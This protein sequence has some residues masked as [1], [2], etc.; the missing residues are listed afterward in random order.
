MREILL[1]HNLSPVRVLD[2]GHGGCHDRARGWT[3]GRID[4]R[5]STT[6]GLSKRTV[7]LVRAPSRS[8]GNCHCDPVTEI[9]RYSYAALHRMSFGINRVMRLPDK[10]PILFYTSRIGHE[11]NP[12]FVYLVAFVDAFQ[13]FRWL[14]PVYVAIRSDAH[15]RCVGP[16]SVRE[17]RRIVSFLSS[18]SASSPFYEA[19]FFSFSLL[20][21][22]REII[23]LP[24][25]RY[26]F[27][28]FRSHYSQRDNYQGYSSRVGIY[29]ARYITSLAR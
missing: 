6:S 24:R 29:C 4:S 26:L 28:L 3:R 8:R 5:P 12:V 14:T 7:L 13:N 2:V 20:L 23:A 18:L 19:T 25:P 17:K 16:S 10:S 27:I 15:V 11:I 21:Q 22:E 9:A 1:Y